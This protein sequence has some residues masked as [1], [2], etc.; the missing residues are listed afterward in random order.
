[1]SC[2]L[3]MLLAFSAA[4]LPVVSRQAARPT[5]RT[6]Q[7]S[8]V[9]GDGSI[10]RR[11]RDRQEFLAVADH[12]LDACPLPVE[13]ISTTRWCDLHTNGHLS[14]IATYGMASGDFISQTVCKSHVWEEHRSP[15]DLGLPKDLKSAD[16]GPA[17]VLDVGG[18]MGTTMMLFA[19]SGYRVTV[20]EAMT[21]NR[22]LINATLCA[23]PDIKNLVSVE[24]AIVST[25]EQ[26][27]AVCK[28]CIDFGSDATVL[29]P[30]DDRG[31]ECDSWEPQKHK[32]MKEEVKVKTLDQI[33]AEHRLPQVDVV[34]MDIEGYECQAMKGANRLLNEIKPRYIMSELQNNQPGGA[35]V[36]CTPTEFIDIFRKANY[37]VFT[38]R[39]G[40]HPLVGDP[41]IE[42]FQYPNFFFVRRS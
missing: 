28:V 7:H 20:I 12:R 34:K 3:Y 30:G 16:G 37:D 9:N 36:G 13:D 10:I 21:Q 18:N 1:M 40:G 35:L 2:R 24:A 38:D 27:G 5:Q 31:T 23:N 4:V 6:L 22:K 26:A 15:E 11:Q 33:V 25:P 32:K 39:F 29:C 42:K 19:K 14:P 17:I 41:K 8:L